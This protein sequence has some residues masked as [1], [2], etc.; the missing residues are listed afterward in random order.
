MLGNWY[1]VAMIDINWKLSL[2]LTVV[3]FSRVKVS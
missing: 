2:Q 1:E 3:G